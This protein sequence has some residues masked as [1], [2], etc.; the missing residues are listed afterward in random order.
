MDDTG[1]GTTAVW[2]HAIEFSRMPDTKVGHRE[3]EM[4]VF[5]RGS[6][7]FVWSQGDIH[8]HMVFFKTDSINVVTDAADFDP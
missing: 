6:E 7:I 2:I 5:H 4:F 3:F 1:V 8:I